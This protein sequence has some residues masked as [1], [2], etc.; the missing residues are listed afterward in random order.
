MSQHERIAL[1]TDVT[2]REVTAL[3]AAHSR[4]STPELV[5]SLRRKVHAALKNAALIGRL[6]ALDPKPE[7]DAPIDLRD[8]LPG[9]GPRHLAVRPPKT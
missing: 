7:P 2:V 8:T 9:L 1:L 5:G 4:S 6:H 3:L